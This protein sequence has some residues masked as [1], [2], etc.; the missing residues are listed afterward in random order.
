MLLTPDCFC[1]VRVIGTDGQNERIILTESNNIALPKSLSVLDS[2]LY[3][4]DPKYDKLERFDLPNGDNS[5]L[6]MDNES[7][8]RTFTIYRK[9]P[10]PNHPCL[11][12][13]GGCQQLCLPAP[14]N[15]RVCACSVGHR[16]E[17]EVQCVAYR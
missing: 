2:R 9:R 10:T 8:L 1:Q 6:L 15:S 7:E 12:N 11:S 16:V 4:L 14:G 13:N 5:R 17:N 3:L